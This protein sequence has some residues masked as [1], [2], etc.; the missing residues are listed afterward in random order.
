LQ[1]IHWRRYARTLEEGEE[2]LCCFLPAFQ[3]STSLKEL[4]MELDPIGGPSSLA[5]EQMLTH[6]QSLQSLTLRCPTGCLD[7]VAVAAARSGLQK[8]TTLQEFTLVLRDATPLSP[9]LT[10]LRD[11]PFLRR[12]CLHGHVTDL[13]GLE[14][15]LL[16]DN[17]KIT[18]LDIHGV[19]E[20]A[21][22]P[23]MVLTQAL[24]RRPTLTKLE[25]HGFRLDRDEAVLLRM[26]LCKY[27]SLQSLE[28]SGH[29]GS[30]GLAE[31]APALY[32]NTMS[33]KV[34]VIS[35]NNLKD[36]ESA[37]LLRDI[38]RSNKTITKLD[39]SYNAF[40]EFLGAVDCIA[41]GLG[42]NSTLLKINLSSCCLGDVGVST[43]ARNLGSRNTALHKLSLKKNGITSTGIGVLLE[44]MEQ[45]SLAT[46]LDLDRN[47][48]IENKGA[49]LIARSLG[50]NAL[51]NLTRLSLS[52]CG[53]GVD[54]FIALMSAMEQNISL[55]QLD[56][57]YS[58]G[59][60]ERAFLAFAESLPKIKVLQ[61]VDFGWCTGLA[62][63]MA[64]LLAG[65]CKN[66][67]LF[68]VQVAN[69]APSSVPPSPEDMARCAGGWMQEMQRLGHRNRF[70]PLICAPKERL[71]SRGLWPHALARVATLP[72]VIFGVLRSKP[73][74]VPSEN[75]GSKETAEVPS[76]DTG[77][78]EA[79][80]DTGIPK[81][82]KHG[83][84]TSES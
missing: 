29:L 34:L 16:S 38:L 40:G 20:Y 8:N 22:V 45:R 10:S 73:K 37:E 28:L 63:A 54:G 60:T 1:R 5:F 15:V 17:S 35:D 76:G 18:E 58:H 59:L 62:S 30:T 72:N 9:I 46:G 42:S 80:E 81:K 12:L 61:Q 75:M 27:P 66:T 50:N 64:L 7:D 11:H 25:L 68:G 36:M 3:E 55:L 82:R 19:S 24:A 71:P 48:N 44:T 79:A 67:S 43:L 51:P 65:F 70:L 6:T 83:W 74:L 14:T 84:L 4:D 47:P 78:K 49:S 13:D 52:N 32:R 56:L 23:M 77:C 41:E 26:A 39:L 69:C 21:V 33:M 2:M 31:L 57:R 53:I